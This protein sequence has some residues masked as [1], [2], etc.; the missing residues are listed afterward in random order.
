LG[1]AGTTDQPYQYV[2]ALGYYQDDNGL[3]LLT[4]RYYDPNAGRF[5]T[6]DPIGYNGGYNLYAYVDGNPVEGIDPSGECWIC[7]LAKQVWEIVKTV[8]P[9][10]IPDPAGTLMSTYDP[11]MGLS[12]LIAQVAKDKA[13]V[14]YLQGLPDSDEERIQQLLISAEA[15]WERDQATLTRV[16][17][18]INEETKKHKK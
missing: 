2:G 11:K 4:N 14:D 9:Y 16:G 3:Q 18:R 8:V 5:T 6:V 7:D 12:V 17:Q 15:R 1:H 10:G 13:Y